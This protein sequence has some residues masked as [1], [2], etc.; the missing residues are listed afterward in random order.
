MGTIDLSMKNLRNLLLKRKP[1]TTSK[2]PTTNII[3]SSKKLI[4]CQLP[5]VEKK[6]KLG[7]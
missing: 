4:G 2:T 6:V 7:I 5:T 1:P 3:N